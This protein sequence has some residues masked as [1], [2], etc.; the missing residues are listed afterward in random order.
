MSWRKYYTGFRLGLSNEFIYRSNWIFWLLRHLI[1]YAGVIYLMDA[2]KQGAGSYSRDQLITYVLAGAFLSEIVSTWGMY[3]MANEIAEGDLTNY[4]LRPVNYFGLSLARSMAIRL[5]H[6]ISSVLI[7]VILLLIFPTA[8]F[9]VQNDPIQFLAALIMLI[10]AVAI[11]QLISFVGSTLAFWAYRAQGPR[12]LI[13]IMVQFLSGGLL[14]LD[15]FPEWLQRV[16]YAT[17]FPS[18]FYAPIK[19]Y[20]GDFSMSEIVKAVW[21]Q[22]FWIAFLGG[23]L[24]FIWKK[25]LKSYE[26]Y[27]R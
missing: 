12:W 25:G 4:I 2:L 9:F 23:L 7:V 20:L 18:L 17:P 5:V 15:L 21:I 14:P 3:R 6:L 1:V 24:Y 10:G 8:S 13:L 22:V 19:I 27:G 26:A 16:L 11:V